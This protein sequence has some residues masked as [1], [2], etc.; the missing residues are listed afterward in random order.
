MK[1]KNSHIH[2]SCRPV[3]GRSILGACSVMLLKVCSKDC[4]GMDRMATCTN[5]GDWTVTFNTHGCNC[6]E[7]STG[8]SFPYLH[9]DLIYCLPLKLYKIVTLRASVITCE[10]QTELERL[11]TQSLME[12]THIRIIHNASSLSPVV[13]FFMPFQ[14]SV[15]PGMSQ[16][17]GYS[18]DCHHFHW[19]V[20]IPSLLFFSSSAVEMVSQHTVHTGLAKEPFSHTVNP[21]LVIV[22][23]VLA[24]VGITKRFLSTDH[25]EI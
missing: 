3:M 24:Q 25:P 16:T 14:T 12:V 18:N 22:S 9:V 17:R 11:G 13:L 20:S 23:T 6:L 7:R 10:I 5:T 19:S 15:N 4:Y 8:L 21:L 1:C 2:F